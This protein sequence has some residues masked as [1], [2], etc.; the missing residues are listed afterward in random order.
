MD[1]HTL[2]IIVGLSLMALTLYLID[3]RAESRDWCELRTY[4]GFCLKHAPPIPQE[5]P[6]W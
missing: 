5:K 1:R 4:T 2:V 3:L 6:K